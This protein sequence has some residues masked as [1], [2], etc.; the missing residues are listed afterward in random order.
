MHWIIKQKGKA[1]SAAPLIMKIFGAFVITS[2]VVPLVLIDAACSLYHSIYFRIHG[3]PL[4]P[5]KD[6]IVI[7]RHRLTKLNWVQRWNCVYCDYANGLVAWMKAVIN[8]T[9]VYS[10]AI[11]HASKARGQEHQSEYYEYVEFK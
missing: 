3:I 7:D 4:I 6:Y 8:T 1:Y 9:E 11:K 10:C 5:R 2:M